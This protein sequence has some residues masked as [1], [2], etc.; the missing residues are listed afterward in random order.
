MKIAP[1]TRSA[2]IPF[3]SNSNETVSDPSPP[4]KK[5]KLESHNF[6]KNW[7]FNSLIKN[8][9]NG[10]LNRFGL[11]RKGLIATGDK[12]IS[13][14]RTIRRLKDEL[15]NLEAVEMEGGAVAQVAEQEGIPWVIVRVISDNADSNSEI[16]FDQFLKEYI[17][18]LDSISI[19]I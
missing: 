9:N 1:K 19:R 15:P 6:L 18:S 2:R 3:D 16:D 7:M 5:S 14:D 17:C 12:F 4:L 13:E 8:V 11:V 10:K